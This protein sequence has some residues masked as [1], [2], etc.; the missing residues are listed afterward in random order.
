MTSLSLIPGLSTEDRDTLR[1][2][3]KQWGMDMQMT[4][5][6]EELSELGEA[7]TLAHID[8]IHWSEKIF[9]E[10]ADVMVCFSQVEDHL[11]HF[12]TEEFTRTLWMDVEKHAAET[13]V[14]GTGPDNLLLLHSLRVV[15]AFAKSRRYN[16]GNLLWNYVIISELGGLLRAIQR[17]E[18]YLKGTAWICPYPAW[19]KVMTF[20]AAKLARL[21]MRLDEAQKAAVEEEE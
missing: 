4:I 18:N 20:Y 12:P 21:G 5:F 2:A 14:D 15:K 6:E 9:E 13:E 17:T 10:L 16:N 3:W 1:D 8:H 19:D 11:R 7:I